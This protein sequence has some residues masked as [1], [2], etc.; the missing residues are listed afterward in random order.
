MA[1]DIGEVVLASL[2]NPAAGIAT[3][4]RKVAQ[5]AKEESQTSQ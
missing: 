5:K 4:I 1:P 3:V 2:T